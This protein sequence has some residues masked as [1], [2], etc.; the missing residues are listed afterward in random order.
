MC[1]VLALLFA[2]HSVQHWRALQYL[3][4]RDGYWNYVRRVPEPYAHLDRRGIVKQSTR[5]KVSDD[6]RGRRAARVGAE[7]NAM[8]EA[9][10]IGLGRGQAADAHAAY[11][12][13]RKRARLAGFDY[14]SSADLA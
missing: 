9:F 7:I 13:A 11:V 5:I 4:K 10:W 1:L 2:Q 12:A 3:T 6:P 8:N 14:L